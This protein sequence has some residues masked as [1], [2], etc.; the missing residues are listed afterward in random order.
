MVDKVEILVEEL[1]IGTGTGNLTLT[2]KSARR[3]F[4]TAYGLGG[5]DK[6]YYFILHKTLDEYEFGTG[7]MLDATTLVRDTVLTS[8]NADTLV[9]FG[10]G[11]KEVNS[12]FFLPAGVSGQIWVSNGPGNQG[13]YQTVTPG[14]IV[15]ENFTSPADH[16]AGVETNLVLAAS[17]ISE[18]YVWV[19][20][21][22]IPQAGTT[23]I[24]AGNTLT[25]T[26]LIPAYVDEIEVKIFIPGTLGVEG[27]N[28]FESPQRA[29]V[30]GGE[31]TE[32]HPFGVRPFIYFAELINIST[33]HNF[34][35]GDRTLPFNAETSIAG[36]GKGIQIVPDTSDLVCRFGDD[37]NTFNILDKNTGAE[38]E[39]T[40]ANWEVILKAEK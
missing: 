23:F 31:I 13:T 4:G 27:D 2:S 34:S 37:A 18:S 10:A 14:N 32:P 6:F 33:E 30:A 17:P 39:I 25:F 20:F 15:T 16:D 3:A 11:T 36:T 38:V 29:I 24:L 1:S 9:N 26:P 21:K 7:H 35:I 19:T 22:G 40:N 28:R 12:D 5:T 8:S